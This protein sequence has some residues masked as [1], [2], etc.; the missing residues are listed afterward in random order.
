M[1][2]QPRRPGYTEP[3]VTLVPATEANCRTLADCFGPL[4]RPALTSMYLQSGKYQPDLAKKR[5]AFIGLCDEAGFRCAD[6]ATATHIGF[7][8]GDHEEMEPTP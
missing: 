3:Y 8:A 5:G 7:M 1:P 6:N 2:D 4:V